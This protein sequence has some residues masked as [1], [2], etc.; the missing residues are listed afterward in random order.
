MCS[1]YSGTC[2]LVVDV[3]VVAVVVV[4][5]VAVAV[6]DDVAEG[7]AVGTDFD[8]TDRFV[9]AVNNGNRLPVA[10]G[11][12]LLVVAYVLPEQARVVAL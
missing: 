9:A 10:F 12:Y 7:A 6:V 8:E 3:D 1:R 11:F 2:P 5:A 4:D